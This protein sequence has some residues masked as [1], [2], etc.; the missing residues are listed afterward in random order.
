VALPVTHGGAWLAVGRG[1][2]VSPQLE[3]RCREAGAEVYA[4]LLPR[5]AEVLQLAQPAVA[6]GQILPPERAL[7][8]YVRDRVVAAAP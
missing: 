5:A 7:P 4:D 3:Q 8:V 2:R 1:L 6:A